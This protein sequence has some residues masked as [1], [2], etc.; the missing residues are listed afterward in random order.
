MEHTK[1]PWQISLGR[2]AT[3]Y[4]TFSIC[5]LSGTKQKSDEQ[6]K[7]NAIYMDY[8][9]NNY[10]ELLAACKK[11]DTEKLRILADWLDLKDAKASLKEGEDFDVEVQLDLRR[12][13]RIIEQAISNC[14]PKQTEV[15]RK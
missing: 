4:P 9:V 15:E 13:A 1:I 11:V 6:Q 10:D 14:K 12:W 5:G 7:I 3:G 2:D 8:C